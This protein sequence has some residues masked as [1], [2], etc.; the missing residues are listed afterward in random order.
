M[1][2]LQ[3]PHVDLFA[4]FAMKV[5][6]PH[7]GQV[8]FFL[9]SLSPAFSYRFQRPFFAPFEGFDA[10]FAGAGFCGAAILVFD[11]ILIF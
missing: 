6:E 7:F 4:C 8:L 11:F 1:V 5:P 2:Y 10:D 9:V 3:A